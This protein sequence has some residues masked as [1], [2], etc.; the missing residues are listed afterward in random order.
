MNKITNISNYKKK[1]EKRFLN[2]PIISY[3]FKIDN[4]GVFKPPIIQTKNDIFQY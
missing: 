2:I 3:S 4:P 1:K